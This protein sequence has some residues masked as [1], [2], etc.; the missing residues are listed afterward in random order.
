MGARPVA[1]H[2]QKSSTDLRVGNGI[3]SDHSPCFLKLP[4]QTEWGEC[5]RSSNRNFR[6][7][8]VNGKYPNCPLSGIPRASQN[9]VLEYSKIFGLPGC[10]ISF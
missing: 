5:I 10:H 7:S 3:A 1:K 4:S 6:F 9:V 8:H 2:I